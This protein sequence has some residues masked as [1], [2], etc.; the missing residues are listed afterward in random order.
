M[1]VTTNNTYASFTGRDLSKLERAR[2]YTSR[3]TLSQHV[4]CEPPR[5]SCATAGT[6]P[7]EAAWCN[8]VLGITCVSNAQRDYPFGAKS[9]TRGHKKARSA[10]EQTN[11]R[12]LEVIYMMP[13]GERQC[14]PGRTNQAFRVTWVAHPVYYVLSS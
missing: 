14:W 4:T 6:F 2:H 5:S 9:G 13:T 10:V 1:G 12:P 3:R 7:A 11:W 8:A